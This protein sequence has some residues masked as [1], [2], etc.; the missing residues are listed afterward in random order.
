MKVGI[1]IPIG[2]NGWLIS[3]NAPQYKPTFELNKQITL[4]AEHYGFDFALSM[5]KL[6]GFGGKTEFWDHNLESFTLMA[7][8]AAVTS[9]IQ[10]FATAPSLV[11]PPAIIARMAATIDSISNGRFGVNLVTGWQRPEYSQMG[12]WPGDEFFS[13]RYEYLSEYIQVLRDLWGTG[14]SD[15]KGAH[16]QM[17][18]C[19][20]SPQPQANMK[21][22]CAGQSDAG[23]A[24]SAQH[25]DHNFCFGKGINTPKAFAPAAQ[26]LIEASRETGRDVTTFVLM[27]VIADETDE[28]ARAKWEHY[29]AGVDEEAVAWL[30]AQG[31]VDKTSGADTNVRQMAD[32]TNAVNI[33][34]GTLVGSYANVARMLDEVAEVEGTEGVLLTFDDFIAGVEAF[35]QRIQ[36]LMKSRI[37]VATP[38][39]SQAD[40]Q[41]AAVGV[42][43]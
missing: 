9:R 14:K 27:M 15:F 39:P 18:D 17:D 24:F 42:A 2:N 43:S 23:M 8:L 25:A 29:K 3:E 37:E 28:A 21:V 12:M 7:G 36:P 1:F 35:G 20:V 19:R 11:M 30:G 40:S 10:L 4:A 31:A 33:N 13:N 41:P 16:F 34:M 38:V 26:K 32:R 22:I 5:I 6:R